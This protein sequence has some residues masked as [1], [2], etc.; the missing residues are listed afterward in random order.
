MIGLSDKN[1]TKITPLKKS[2]SIEGKNYTFETGK[3]GLLTNGAVMMSDDFENVMFTTAWF[4]TEWL[5]TQADF[6]PLVVDYVEKFYATWLIGWNRFQRREGRPS[7]NA[8]L[9]ARLIDRPIRPMFPKGIINDTQL[10]VNVLS[11]TGEKELGTWWITSSSL[12]LMMTWAPFEWP[13]SWVKVITTKDGKF[14]YD[15]STEEEDNARLSLVVAGTL[16][17]ITMVEA[18]WH[19]VSDEEMMSGL[20]YAH[21]IIID[22]CNAQIDYIEDYKKQFGIPEIEATYN[23]PNVSSYE[24]VKEFLTEEKLECL[25]EK[26][27]KE[28]QKEL[29]N[30]DTET[31]EFFKEKGLLVDASDSSIKNVCSLEEWQSCVDEGSIW[32][33]VYKRVKEVMRKNVLVNSKRLDGRKLDEVR[34]VIW[35]TGLLP[36]THGSALFQRGMTQALSIVTLWGP[37][38]ALTLEWMMPESSKRYFHQYNFPPY[39][40]GEVRM[41]RWVGR[42]EIGHWALAERALVPVLPDLKDFPY[43]MRV[44]SEIT[45]CNGS[46]SM[47]S[48]CGST[49][50][51]MHAGVPIKAPVAWVA[52]W[53]IYDDNTGDYKILSDIQAQEDFLWDMDFKLARTWNGITAMQ[54]DVKIK[55]LK[56]QVFRDAFSQWKEATDYIL[57]KMLEV[58]PSVNTELSKY[59]PLIMTMEIPVDKIRAIIGKWWENVQRLE[60]EYDVRISIADDGITTI[61]ARNQEW[62]QKA[63]SEIKEM[64]WIPD[65]WYKWVWKIVKIIDG[66]WAIVEFRWQTGMIHISKLAATRVVK[67]ED[68]VNLW[69]MVEFEIIQVDTA[70]WKIGLK[71]KFDEIVK[72]VEVVKKEDSI[73]NEEKKSDLKTEENIIDNL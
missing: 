55:W 46:S 39:S 13:V 19:E 63:I 26:G 3:L 62:W 38:D 65:V 24:V 31:K 42:R 61:T 59:A 49:M 68:V 10:L 15:P 60:A 9:T 36:R 41:M 18:G 58:Q 14:I 21:K 17:A 64:L 67:V 69:D 50:S 70:K 33:L 1:A 23:N 2:Y 73:N 56:M 43:T 7:D 25:Y 5:N 44:V 48:V 66:T 8:T 35:E 22:L 16:D 53:M 54:L 28:F 30:L 12:A 32:A 57:S 4:K 11:A 20:E 40:V 27:K 29:D 45:T 47:A 52:M 34:E 37:D 72:K 71:K 51:L 6:F